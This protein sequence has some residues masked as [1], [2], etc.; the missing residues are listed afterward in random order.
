MRRVVCGLVFACALNGLAH[1]Q[2]THDHAQPSTPVTDN[3]QWTVDG[4]LFFG[5]NYQHR[6]FT[7]FSAW[8]SQNWLMAGGTRRM[9]SGTFTASTMLSLEP[10]TIKDIGSPQAF[11]TGE[12]FRRAPLID[13]RTI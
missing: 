12:T 3:W 11:Q 9:R 13:F 10:W 7:D 2:V 8:E 1:A 4:T 6:K 5:Y